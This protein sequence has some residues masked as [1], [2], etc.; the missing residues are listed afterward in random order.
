MEWHLRWAVGDTAIHH[1]A[2][3]LS[4]SSPVFIPFQTAAKLRLFRAVFPSHFFLCCGLADFFINYP[5]RWRYQHTF[6]VGLSRCPLVLLLW[7]NLDKLRGNE[8]YIITL[9]E[10]CFSVQMWCLISRQ[11]ASSA[12]IFCRFVPLSTARLLTL[13][14]CCCLQKNQEKSRTNP[15]MLYIKWY[16]R[17]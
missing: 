6:S 3:R 14:I 15:T 13:L 8:Y 12:H 9:I 16:Y 7:L 10:I 11:M 17:L 1:D 2:R 5:D 4:I